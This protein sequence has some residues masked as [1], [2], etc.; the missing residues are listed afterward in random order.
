VVDGEV[1]AGELFATIYKAVGI[2]PQKNYYVG[3]RPIPLVELDT[4]PID[5]VLA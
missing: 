2:D 1:G 4:D 5:A 3:S